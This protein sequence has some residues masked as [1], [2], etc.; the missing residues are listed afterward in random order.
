MPRLEQTKEDVEEINPV[1][2]FFNSKQLILC[3][4]VWGALKR[5]KVLD[6]FINFAHCLFAV[7]IMVSIL[8]TLLGC[9]L[10]GI[11]LSAP[12]GPIGIL[13]IQRTLNKGRESGLY[14][15]VGASLSDLFYCLLSGLGI[16]IVTDFIDGHKDLLQVI[17]SA[18]LLI[19]AIYLIVKRNT[20]ANIKET[21][22][23]KKETHYRD[24]VSGFAFTLSNPLI[25]F[26][27]FPLF[28]RFGFPA[29]LPWP[30]I[31]IGYVLIFTGALCWW[32]MITYLVNKVRKHFNIRSMW[33]INIIIGTIILILSL[34][35]LVSGIQSFIATQG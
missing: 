25:I 27:I 8:T 7:M 35:G 1:A 4:T 18:I 5:V 34:Y 15:G 32:T 12:M 10:T 16:S 28:A 30:A 31:F 6:I 26:L 17:G 11:I 19:Y 9:F 3:S 13:C 22:L 21:N 24:L 20:A 23:D 33:I 2:T 29:G 14:T